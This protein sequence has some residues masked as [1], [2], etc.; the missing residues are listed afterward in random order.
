MQRVLD[1]DLDFFVRDV[2]YWPGDDAERRDPADYA[3]WTV[4][5]SIAFLRDRCGLSSRLPGMAVE[6]HGELFFR[7]RDAIDAGT[8]TPPFHVT[9]LDAHAD[10]GLGDSGFIYLMS[11][12]L[13]EPVEHRRD[14]RTGDGGL[15]DGNYLVFA[16]AC[17]WLSELVYVP[18][19]RSHHDIPAFVMDGFDV[20]AAHIR[21]A[22]VMY[23]EL[24]LNAGTLRS[25]RVEHWEPPVPFSTTS[26]AQYHAE[27]SFDVVCL[28]RSPAY[29]PAEADEIF[30]A[31]RSCFIDE[32]AF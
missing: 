14:P 26:C 7:W 16:I 23:D 18:T 5:D 19:D 28:A 15:G 32:S 13:F 27:G 31:V 3:P 8:L 22:A 9:H 11:S 25:A 10:L 6:H 1:V 30:D 2:V 29:T 21:L 12:L 17:R 24:E 4:E 20:G